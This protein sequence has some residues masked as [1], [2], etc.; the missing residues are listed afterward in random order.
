MNRNETASCVG[1]LDVFEL[2]DYDNDR[3]GVWFVA[4]P[5]RTSTDGCCFL[6]AHFR[7]AHHRLTKIEYEL[8]RETMLEE[9]SVMVDA[10]VEGGIEGWQG[11]VFSRQGDEALPPFAKSIEVRLAPVSENVMWTVQ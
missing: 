3:G 10:L 6:E 2:V 11:R 7:S 4:G 9:C 1:P 8:L 5:V